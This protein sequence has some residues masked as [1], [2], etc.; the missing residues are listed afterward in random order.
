MTNKHTLFN[1][2]QSGSTSPKTQTPR[3]AAAGL[4]DPRKEHDACGLGFI[5]NMKGKKSHKIVEDGIRIL[6][7]L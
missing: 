5:A 3:S 6:E 2:F 4:Y 1:G 7:N